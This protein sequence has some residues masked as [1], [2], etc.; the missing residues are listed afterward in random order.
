MLACNRKFGNL[1]LQFLEPPL[2]LHPICC[3]LLECLLFHR[4]Q[5]NFSLLQVHNHVTLDLSILIVHTDL[6]LMLYDTA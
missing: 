2:N 4:L 3:H 5:F 1:S 6:T